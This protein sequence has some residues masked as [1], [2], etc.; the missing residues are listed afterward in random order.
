MNGDKQALALAARD[1]RRSILRVA[2]HAPS[3]GVHISPALSLVDILAALYGAKL[4]YEP[5]DIMNPNRDTFILSKGHGALALY[6]ALCQFG[7]ISQ[8][9]L[10]SFEINGSPLQVHPTKYP[11]LGIDFSSGSLAQGLAFGIGLTLSRRLK[12][13]PWHT[14]ILVGDGECNEG[15]IWEGAFFAAHQK[16]DTLTVIV[17]R[18]GLQSDGFTQD[19]LNQNLPALW[20]ACGW[21]VIECDG[22]DLNALLGAL[23]A[24][25][26][27]KPKAI[28]AHTIKGKGVSFMEN[29]KEYH[30]NRLSEQQYLAAMVEL[31]G[32]IL[33]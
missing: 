32:E 14:Y 8:D 11:E 31:D 28:V 19:I 22:N 15:A 21:E 29:N 23:D 24:P 16:L 1:I 2:Y 27:G 18:N 17:D 25:H 10:D 7:I 30:R 5:N 13:Q 4:R 6:S 20:R 9:V 3:D 12:K 33:C 26:N